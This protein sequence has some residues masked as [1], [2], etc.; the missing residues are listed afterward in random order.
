MRYLRQ[1]PEPP[2]N[3]WIDWYWYYDGFM[4][5]HRLDRVLPDGTFELIINLKD[6]P[7]HT[8]DPT[9][10]R[11][12][13]SYNGAWI[14][15][16]QSRYLVI[17]TAPNSS[18]MGVHFKPGGA[19]PFLGFP[20]EEL[21][22]RV[23]E[24]DSLWGS[25]AGQLREALLEAASPAAKFSALTQ[26]L[27]CRLKKS[28]SRSH[29]VQAALARFAA[30][31]QTATIAEFA[32]SLGISQKHFIHL[33]KNEVGLT[34]KRFCRISRFQRVL[35]DVQSC[36]QVQWS[37]VAVAGGFYD[38]SHLINE[39]EAFSGISPAAYMDRRNELL[40]FIPVD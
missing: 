3:Q 19:A 4:P 31:P 33:F 18:M 7:R 34:P 10:L 37:D 8:F 30:E 16:S 39:F 2:F 17:D 21:A 36:K 29:P 15:G 25:T 12:E 5:D 35:Q 32:Q 1:R 20:A 40:N 24:L 26:F 9:S 22:G 11:P 28:N 27:T 14:S 38:Q 23:E 13:R 6:E